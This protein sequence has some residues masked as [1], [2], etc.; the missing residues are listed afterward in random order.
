[1]QIRCGEGGGREKAGRMCSRWRPKQ[2]CLLPQIRANRRHPYTPYEGVHTP[3]VRAERGETDRQMPH[4]CTDKF[5]ATFS[6]TLIHILV[7]IICSGV[8]VTYWNTSESKNNEH[9]LA[10]RLTTF[11][12]YNISVIVICQRA[13]YT[14]CV[15]RSECRKAPM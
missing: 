4:N 6:V 2:D 15:A 10:V 1:M 5:P 7:D 12:N 13:A 3:G 8:T 14:L 9:S 11:I